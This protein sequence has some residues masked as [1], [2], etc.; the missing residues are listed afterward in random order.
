MKILINYKKKILFKFEL[1]N[2]KN[3]DFYIYKEIIIT[4][5]YYVI[6]DC[7]RPCLDLTLDWQAT[8]VEL[9]I[10]FSVEVCIQTFL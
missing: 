5:Q 6:V 10:K 7:N 8:K 4:F 1:D 2:N 3:V 9:L